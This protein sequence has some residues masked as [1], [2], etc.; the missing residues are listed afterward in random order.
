MNRLKSLIAVLGS[1]LF[2]AGLMAQER[3]EPTGHP[4]DHFSLHG[5]LELFKKAGNP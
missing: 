3:N 2:G 1:V 4:G 5:P